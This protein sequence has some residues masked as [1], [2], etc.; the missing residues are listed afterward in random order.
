MRVVLLNEHEEMDYFGFPIEVWQY[1]NDD[2]CLQKKQ[3][4]FFNQII[5]R[6]AY[7]NQDQAVNRFFGNLMPSHVDLKLIL[8]CPLN[9]ATYHSSTYDDKND[10]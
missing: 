2:S 3:Y 9:F 10:Y 8:V 6:C 7:L 4:I 1:P 5:T